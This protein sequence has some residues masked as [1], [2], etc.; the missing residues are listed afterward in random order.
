MILDMSVGLIIAVLVSFFTDNKSA[1]LLFFGVLA[2][3]APDL[4]AL[5]FVARGG[6]FDQ[7]AHEHREL[8][9]KPLLISGIGS[10]FFFFFSFSFGTVWLINT[11]WHFYNDTVINGWGVMWLWPFKKWYFCFTK[12]TPKNIIKTKEEQREIAAK[13]G[14]PNW[15]KESYFKINIFLIYEILVFL[16]AIISTVFFIKM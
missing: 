8:L 7:F 1:I 3:L 6:K 13:F 11:L 4:D 16:S 2:A 5:I 14:N 12:E 15:V 10:I 9:H